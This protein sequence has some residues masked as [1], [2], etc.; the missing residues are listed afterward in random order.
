MHHPKF[1]AS[2]I[3]YKYIYREENKTNHIFDVVR[4]TDND[5]DDNDDHVDDDDDHGVGGK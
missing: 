1:R 2:A 3:V 4:G 5:D